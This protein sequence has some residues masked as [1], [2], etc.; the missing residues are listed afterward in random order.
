MWF[1]TK[2]M[3][4]LGLVEFDE[5]KNQDRTVVLCIWP[6]AHLWLVAQRGHLFEVTSWSFFI[7]FNMTREKWAKIKICNEKKL[8]DPPLIMYSSLLYAKQ[9]WKAHYP[10]VLN[11]YWMF[12]Q[13][14]LIPT[15]HKSPLGQCHLQ[16]HCK[17]WLWSF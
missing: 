17:K 15:R 1:W 16:L 9:H 7:Y 5:Y 8:N 2:L 12:L 11:F 13:R 10:Q 14:N 3:S 4:Y 6:H